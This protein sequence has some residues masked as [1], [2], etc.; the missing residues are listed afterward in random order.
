[1]SVRGVGHLRTQSYIVI[2]NKRIYDFTK[3]VAR[4]HYLNAATTGVLKLNASPGGL[5]TH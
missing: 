4:A 3:P 5:I 1:M 2:R